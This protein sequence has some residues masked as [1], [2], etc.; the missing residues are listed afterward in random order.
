MSTS[1]AGPNVIDSAEARSTNAGAVYRL[2]LLL[3]GALAAGLVGLV[4]GG[5]TSDADGVT[6]AI[7]ATNGYVGGYALARLGLGDVLAHLIALIAGIF[8]AAIA[9]EPRETIDLARAG[10]WGGI[11]A[12]YEDV[13][14][15][16]TRSIET[17][18][19]F[20]PAV[21]TIAIGLIMWLMG[22]TA[23]WM[24]FRRG[25]IFWAIALPGSILLA[26]LAADR[27]QP[28]WLGLAYIAVSLGAW[29]V[30]TTDQRDS[31][32]H[33]AGLPAPRSFASWSTML[34]FLLATLAVLAALSASYDL[35]DRIKERAFESGDRMAAWVE[36]R[37]DS[38]KAPSSA[39]R[40]ATGNYGAFSD[41]F[42]VGDGVPTGD[43]AL[44]IMQSD[45]EHYL[46]A[47]R[48]NEYDG[49]GW[50]E[51]TG[52]ESTSDAGQPPR[53]AFQSDQPMNLPRQ[54]IQDR[55]PERAT[56]TLLQRS[57][58]RLLLTIDQ[59]YAASQATL[60]RVGWQQ[61]DAAFIVGQTDLAEVPVDLRE[62][63]VLLETVAIAGQ[64]DS[65]D[66]ILVASP[67]ASEI[68]R[69]RER[70][71]RDYP[72]ETR[73]TIGS[74][75][76]IVLNVD[77]RVPVY[78][79]VLAVFGSDELDGGTYSVIGMRPSVS[80]DDLRLA[81]TAYP[82]YITDTYMQLP[83]TVSDRTQALAASVTAAAG[84]TTPYDQAV[85]LEQYL[86]TNFTY[87]LEAGTAPDGTDIVDYFLFDSKVGRCD[88]YASSMV[89]MLRSLGVPARIVTGFAPVPYDDSLSG[90]VYRGR[91]A[92]AWVEVYFPGFGWI[93]FE[94][95][96]NQ[97]ASSLDGRGDGIEPTPTPEPAP[98]LTPTPTTQI[99][100]PTATPLASPVAPAIVDDPNG[101]SAATGGDYWREIGIA[102]GILAAVA[103]LAVILWQRSKHWR[104]MPVPSANFM[105]L[106]RLGRRFGVVPSPD[107]TPREYAMRF[108]A[109]K[110]AGA[111]G[112]TRVAEAFTRSRYGVD[113]DIVR[114]AVESDEGWR[115]A[116]QAVR[117]WRF[118]RRT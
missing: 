42:K 111:P 36:E 15:G 54:I 40:L 3:L 19:R 91:N 9:L 102:G 101:G 72:V 21:A 59:H 16:F 52:D 34:G 27:T 90:Y 8:A 76:A 87:R 95:T 62:L 11:L 107:Q 89:V 12:R 86:R 35:D 103:A 25:W 77:G 81:G 69:V 79:D 1:L 29:V 70:L 80:P 38:T 24:T 17:G 114:L 23:A 51:T 57:P 47:R 39:N 105:R 4:V 61:I 7:L 26:A 49:T 10:E 20:E 60:I 64:D 44:V 73:I 2:L 66:A 78:S 22:Y 98:G 115:D 108:G 110:P 94:P 93:P 30:A 46:A 55:V 92:H 28:A 41:Q 48:L 82:S 13:F 5:A 33:S 50:K 113:A 37:I 99:E 58:D 32:W 84:A 83:G 53:I 106:Q 100:Q 18:S 117:D 31:R 118:W 67:A 63:M 68:D 74:D 71:R 56:I 65:G 75:G 43:V 85:A 112:A 96:P 6:L 14:R 116:R 45:S 97:P 104:T 109:A 88:H